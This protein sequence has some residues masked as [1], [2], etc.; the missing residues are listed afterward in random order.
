[1][2]RLLATMPALA[3]AATLGAPAVA[4]ASYEV[5]LA[6]YDEAVASRKPDHPAYAR[7]FSAWSSV[8]EEDRSPA[9]RYHLG[10]MYYFGIGG[11]PINQP[12]GLELIEGAAADGYALADAY[13]GLLHDKGDG[14]MV[15]NDESLALERYERAAEGRNCAAIKRLAQAHEQGDLGLAPDPERAAAYQ[16][17]VQDCVRR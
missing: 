5:G 17:R 9:L 15:P 16:A 4:E 6:A 14:M 8:A 12:L 10:M 11:A 7:A 3:F 1:M 2:N 13:I